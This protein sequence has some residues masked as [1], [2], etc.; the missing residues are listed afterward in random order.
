M[1]PYKQKKKKPIPLLFWVKFRLH[2]IFLSK[3]ST[4]AIYRLKVLSGIQ[5]SVLLEQYQCQ[6]YHLPSWSNGKE[7]NFLM[8]ASAQTKTLPIVYWLRCNH[9]WSVPYH[10]WDELANSKQWAVI[11][12]FLNISLEDNRLSWHIQAILMFCATFFCLNTYYPGKQVSF[13]HQ[14]CRY[15]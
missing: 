3:Y 6:G 13:Q 14:L 1:L 2:S 5:D 15:V 9:G 10:T 8:T 12:T 7:L 4:E 11:L